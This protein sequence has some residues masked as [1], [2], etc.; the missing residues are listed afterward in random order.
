[1]IYDVTF[2]LS[3]AQPSSPLPDLVYTVSD[4]ISEV[5]SLKFLAWPSIHTLDVLSVIVPVVV[6][7]LCAFF[8]VI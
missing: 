6:E 2:P 4:F 8:V 7:I 1:M 3:G 5:F